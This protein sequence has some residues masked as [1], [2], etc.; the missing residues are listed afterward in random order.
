MVFNSLTF[1]LFFPLVLLLHHLPL[2]WTVKKFNLLWLSY[3]FY[4]AWNP[5]FVALLWISTLMDYH[6][7]KAM[8]RAEEPRKRKALLLVS[9]IANL[10]MLAFFKYGDFVIQ[11]W[12]VLSNALGIP[13]QPPHWDIILPA[14]ISFYTFQTL[15]YT[16]DV[17]RREIKSCDSFTDFALF[18]A[19]FPQLVA[20]PIVRAVDFLPQLDAPKKA[21]RDQMGWGLSLIVLGMFEKVV[22]AD[23][24]MAPVADA[25]FNAPEKISTA[26]AWVG[27]IA[28]SGQILFDFGGYSTSAIGAS[29]CLGFILPD[30]FRFPYAAVGFS[31]FWRRWH[32]SLSTWLRDYLY[33]TLGGNRQ[34]YWRTHINLMLTMLIGGLW[35]GASWRFVVWGGLHGAYLVGER[36]LREKFEKEAW[37]SNP[38]FL[39]CMAGF[40]YVLTCFTW[41][42]FRATDFNNAWSFIRAMFGAGAGDRVI[43]NAS[44]IKAATVM[45]VVLIIHWCLR[46]SSVEQ[47]TAKTPAWARAVALAAMIL[48]L[49]LIPGDDRAFIYFQF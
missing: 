44:N 11:N 46:K 45:A 40:T 33:I 7:A 8:D 31:D 15:S 21:S 42:F 37:T 47:L 4:A 35:H 26:Q 32:L 14:G 49:I 29:L 13:Y 6:L 27:V 34:G 1:V 30:N 18:I 3:L 9:L 2:S 5:P 36:L 41:V 24:I 17:Y 25:A 39:V 12:A 48:M 19:F 10:G 22:L 23:G 43:G 20:G 16:I 28:F 38:L